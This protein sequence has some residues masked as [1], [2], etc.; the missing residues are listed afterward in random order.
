MRIALSKEGT[1]GIGCG[2]T[3][4]ESVCG[5]QACMHVCMCAV[6]NQQSSIIIILTSVSP[7]ARIS[8]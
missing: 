1:A 5:V 7:G 8:G 4:V 3:D 2:T 6:Y